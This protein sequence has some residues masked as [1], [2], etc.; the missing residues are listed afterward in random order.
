MLEKSMNR[1]HP[2]DGMCSVFIRCVDHDVYVCVIDEPMSVF[3][4]LTERY[5]LN[6]HLETGVWKVNVIATNTH[7]YVLTHS[8]PP[9]PSLPSLPPFPPLPS[10]PLP[11][12]PPSPPS[13]DLSLKILRDDSACPG[14][15][16]VIQW[17]KGCFD[18][19]DKK[20]VCSLTL[21]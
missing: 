12:L 18:A 2:L 19:L 10:L 7:I 4:F 6:T 8:I 11:S 15:C 5:F 21:Y 3:A 9:S 14:A 16:Q 13:L 1:S 17:V 20:Y